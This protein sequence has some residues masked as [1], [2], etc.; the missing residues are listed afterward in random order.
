MQTGLHL[1]RGLSPVYRGWT[2]HG[3]EPVSMSQC[4]CE[5]ML[6][7]KK[8][9]QGHAAMLSGEA[10]MEAIGATDQRSGSTWQFLDLRC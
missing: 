5:S 7:T 2:A 3:N 6:K 4:D 9:F 8:Q 10:T 1:G